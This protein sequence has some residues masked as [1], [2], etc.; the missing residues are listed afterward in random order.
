MLT[1]YHNPRCRKSREGLE[2]IRNSGKEYQT[3]LYLKD[4]L[5]IPELKALLQQLGIPAEALVRKSE[6]VWKNNYKGKKL[7]EDDIVVALSEHPI[8][9]ERPVVSDGKKAVLGRPPEN[10]KHLL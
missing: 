8:L 2:I 3:R 10:I 1:I 9:M 6:P 7:T 5:E 4:P